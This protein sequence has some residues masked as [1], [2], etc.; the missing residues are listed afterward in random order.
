MKRKILILLASLLIGTVASSLIGVSASNKVTYDAEA[1]K[2][3]YLT[4]SYATEKEKLD[5]MVEQMRAGDFILYIDEVTGE[6]ALRNT[7]TKQ[8]LWSNPFDIAGAQTADTQKYE[9]FSQILLNYTTI[10]S[11]ASSTMN[12]F[13]EAAMR[14]NAESGN[15][16]IVVKQV[17][18]GVRVEYTLGR[19]ETRVLVPRCISKERFETMIIEPLK[20][21]AKQNLTTT[22]GQSAKFLLSK[23]INDDGNTVFYT[24][25]DPNAPGVTERQKRAMYLQ[26]PITEKMPVYVI[27]A[28]ATQVE[29]V[30]WLE[31]AITNFTDY[32]FEDMA[33]DHSMT[34]YTGTDVAPPLFRI[35][36]EYYLTE[37]GLTYRVPANGIR[38]DSTLYRLDNVTILPYLGAGTA[39]S[40]GYTFIPDGS[41]SIVNFADVAMQ[42][43][44]LSGKVYGQ[45]YAYY[46]L[47]GANQEIMRLPVY[48]TVVSKIEY[49]TQTE[50]VD[51]LDEDGNVIGS[52]VVTKQVK[53]VKDSAVLSIITEGEAIATITSKHGGTVNPYN[54]TYATY[55]PRP[56]DSYALNQ[57]SASSTSMWTVVTDRRYTGNISVKIVMLSGEDANYSGMAN[58]YR[59]YLTANGTLTKLDKTEEKVPLFVESFGAIEVS[60]RILGVPVNVKKSL[61]TYDDLQTMVTELQEKG[62]GRVNVKYTSWAN[63]AF[64]QQ[65]FTKLKLEKAT[66]GKGGLADFLAYAKENNA[67]LYPDVELSYVF[68]LSMFDGFNYNKMVSRRVDKRIG[69][70]LLYDDESQGFTVWDGDVI[71][72]Q[73]MS[74]IWKKIEKKYTKLGI[75][76]ISVGSLGENLNSDHHKKRPLNRVEAQS[77]VDT[78]LSEIKASAGEMLVDGG[79][80]YALKYADLI[81]DA[82]LESSRYIYASREV[83]FYAMV[84]HGSLQFAGAPINA[85]P[86][87]DAAVLKI[88]ESG[89]LPFFRVSY[90]NTNELK[91][92]V[93]TSKYFSVDYT[94]WK[95]DIVETYATINEALADLQNVYIV[96]HDAITKKTVCVTY[97]NGVE[98]F[99]NYDRA[100]VYIFKDEDGNYGASYKL[101]ETGKKV[102][103]EVIEKD[104]NGMDIIVEREFDLLLEIPGYSYLRRGDK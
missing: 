96:K 91:S 70:K 23:F 15:N 97:E 4:T 54:T 88:I 39:S 80:A 12:S 71:S 24:L 50:R 73:F 83:P 13:E 67:Y 26:Y 92:D 78:V 63:D 94:T 45:D 51:I 48:G 21:A 18:G 27:D 100:N 90:Q 14:I 32:T 82:P 87:Y 61:T 37:D 72:P 36:I 9:L 84:V 64:K 99:V 11:G 34:N 1:I 17:S 22:D 47:T 8:V 74:D 20:A 35:A 68:N 65:P 85:A 31:K 44:Q 30:N 77:Y 59:E 89:S 33:S 93:T 6:M 52:E 42:S 55:V 40:G 41:G 29:L 3:Q 95:D 56:N 75:G 19:T 7:K 10:S 86:D 79:N 101:D 46:N 69:F 43:V 98:I 53:K 76:G 104:P 49:E 60:E 102:L 57:F 58:A 28:N 66:G 62:I 103:G 81:V 16:Q 25:K 38:F 2:E 5:T